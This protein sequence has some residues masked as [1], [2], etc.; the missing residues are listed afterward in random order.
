MSILGKILERPKIIAGSA[1]RRQIEFHRVIPRTA[2][3]FLTYRCD[4]RCE[5]CNFWR[6]DKVELKANEIAT[7][8]IVPQ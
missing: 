8:G 4:S 3:F 7:L 1:I 6:R 2:L 5:T